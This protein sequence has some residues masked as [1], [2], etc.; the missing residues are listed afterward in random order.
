MVAA[1]V[2]A[3]AQ[4]SINVTS[5]PFSSARQ[6][7]NTLYLS[8]QIPI[9]T[10]GTVVEG[11]VAE[12]THQTMQNLGAVLEENGYGWGDVMKV[13]VYLSDMKH[14]QEMNGVYRTY[15]DGAF[16]ARE[17]VG[18]LQLAFGADMEISA[19]AYKE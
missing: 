10:D 8:G 3:H 17:C 19:I 7:G 18:G 9:R 2:V 15:F 16:P 6:A 5:L 14:Y 1:A 11:S 4:E 12:Q 13:T